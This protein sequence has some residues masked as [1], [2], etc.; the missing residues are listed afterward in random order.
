MVKTFLIIFTLLLIAIAS[1]FIYQSQ[2][3]QSLFVG[4]T[5]TNLGVTNGNLAPCLATPNCVSTQAN[6][7]DPTHYITP[8]KYES[9]PN[10]AQ[11]KLRELLESQKLTK[12]VTQTENYIYAQFTSRLMGFV[13]DVEFYFTPE[14]K[15]I[16]VRSASRLGESDLGVNRQRIEQIRSV[17]SPT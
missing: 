13:D 9:D 12:I 6:I 15:L 3:N 10:T 5:P 7:N 4:T 2:T 8:I 16:H 14:A 1:L 17:I 11:A